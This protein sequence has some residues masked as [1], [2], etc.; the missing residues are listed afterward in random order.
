MRNKKRQPLVA[1]EELIAWVWENDD[2][3]AATPHSR[4]LDVNDQAVEVED[5]GVYK[6]LLTCDQDDPSSGRQ[7]YAHKLDRTLSNILVFADDCRAATEWL[8]SGVVSHEDEQGR[9]A[10]ERRR[11]LK[12]RGLLA[13]QKRFVR[14]CGHVITGAGAIKVL[15]AR[16]CIDSWEETDGERSLHFHKCEDGL[17][18]QPC[19][20]ETGNTTAM[21][22]GNP[23]NAPA[24]VAEADG[25]TVDK[26][27]VSFADDEDEA[28]VTRGQWK[29]PAG[30]DDDDPENDP[31]L[32]WVLNER[33]ENTM[34]WLSEAAESTAEIAA[35]ADDD[36]VRQLFPSLREMRRSAEIENAQRRGAEARK[37]TPSE[38]TSR[39]GPHESIH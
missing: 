6:S 37:S 32:G 13:N 33:A 2:P 36:T 10:G 1:L 7:V 27:V 31:G 30:S 21:S 26:Y 8:V 4:H 39:S 38:R 34:R 35:E 18:W 28:T 22:L 19:S 9:R 29:R 17:R 3:A 23:Y 5:L 20:S 15:A 25:R 14:L 12:E 16:Q 11:H 24:P